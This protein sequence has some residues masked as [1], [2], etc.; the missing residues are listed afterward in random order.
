MTIKIS[1]P[2]NLMSDATFASLDGDATIYLTNPFG[3]GDDY[4]GHEYFQGFTRTRNTSNVD[5]WVVRSTVLDNDFYMDPWGTWTA[6]FVVDYDD[7]DGVEVHL[8]RIRKTFKVLGNTTLT[9]NASPEPAKKGRTITARG[10]H[11]GFTGWGADYESYVGV[12]IRY[13]F[14]TKSSGPWTYMGYAKTDKRGAYSKGF[15]ARR[16][17]YWKAV[18]PQGRFHISRTSSIDKVIVK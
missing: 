10:V 8:P 15:V 4:D 2:S 14:S 3:D 7:Y 13:Y 16:T 5:T 6:N 1:D 12:K 9:L 11:R 17:G 18:A